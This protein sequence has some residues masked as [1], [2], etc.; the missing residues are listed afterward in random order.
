MFLFG[1]FADATI[2][3]RVWNCGIVSSV[4][5]FH[6]ATLLSCHCMTSFVGVHASAC[7]SSLLQE[8]VE[9]PLHVDCFLET[10]QGC[11]VIKQEVAEMPLHVDFFFLIMFQCQISV[12]ACS[13]RTRDAFF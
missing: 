6:G 3:N 13:P 8:A 5:T 11:I 9:M 12:N 10:V 1:C 4:G 2:F 7:A